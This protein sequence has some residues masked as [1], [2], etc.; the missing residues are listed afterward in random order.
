MNTHQA[1]LH[2]R[3]FMTDLV[4]RPGADPTARQLALLLIIHQKPGP[5]TVRGLATHLD[6]V[7]PA[8]TRS[9]DRMQEFGWVRRQGCSTLD[10]LEA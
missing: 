4:R 1:L 5:H 10:I 6:I 2:L 9:L 3:D 8:V 7:K